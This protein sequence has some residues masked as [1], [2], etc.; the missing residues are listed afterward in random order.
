MVLRMDEA[1]RDQVV[2]KCSSG[3]LRRRLLREADL[4]LTNCIEIAKQFQ[5]SERHATQMEMSTH[6]STPQDTAS[7]V[8]AYSLQATRSRHNSG[9]PQS[10]LVAL[11]CFCSRLSGHKGKDLSC[12]AKGKNCNK[13]GKSDHF[14]SVQIFT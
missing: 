8:N 13:C 12:P 2:E 9:Q 10:S 6:S 7:A 1:I 14:G 11:T 5:V 3:K 4:T